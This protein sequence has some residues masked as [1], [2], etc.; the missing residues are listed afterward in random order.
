MVSGLLYVLLANFNKV[1]VG[2]KDSIRA[3]SLWI[4]FGILELN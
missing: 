3:H 4:T 2:F 1:D